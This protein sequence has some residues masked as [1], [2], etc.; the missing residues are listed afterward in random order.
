MQDVTYDSFQAVA[1]VRVYNVKSQVNLTDYQLFLNNTLSGRY[2]VFYNNDSVIYTIY[3]NASSY[4]L[5]FNKTSYQ[6]ETYFFNATPYDNL[7][8]LLNAGFYVSFLFIDEYT[9]GPFNISSPD[10]LKFVL[11][12]ED[13]TRETLIVSDGQ[14]VFVDCDYTKLRFIPQYG[15]VSYARTFILPWEEVTA[16]GN[17]T[18]YLVNLDT[19]D[20]VEVSFKLD[21]LLRDY[22]NPRVYI[23]KIIND[24]SEQMHADYTDI[25]NKVVA[26]L[27]QYHE[28]TI[29]V[30][31]DNNPVYTL[32]TY[33]ADQSGDKILSL[34]EI[35]ITPTAGTAFYNDVSLTAYQYN[36]TDTTYVAFRYNDSANLTSQVR[37]TYYE[38]DESGS[39]ILDAIY[40]NT[41]GI[42]VT[43]NVTSQFDAGIPVLVKSTMIAT[44]GS[45]HTYG[46]LFFAENS[47]HLA[48]V[49]DFKATFDTPE[50]AR[51]LLNWVVIVLLTGLSL[52]AS[53]KTANWMP[54]FVAG[55]A[56]LLSIFGIFTL[57]GW[58]IGII[59]VFALFTIL[60]AGDRKR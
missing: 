21:D 15:A 9:L 7:S 26:T 18:I 32:G 35:A 10:S 57:N 41:P 50:Q 5:D 24:T 19:T 23:T 38:T 34:Y 8:I 4:A 11:T 56:L 6:T 12:C 37:V 30:Y 14:E 22:D 20:Y 17:T 60:A 46:R 58:I 28:Y 29:S 52:L 48:I 36:V 13:Y 39:V 27:I 47:S 45:T 16:G 42:L 44:H 54:F 51:N 43:Q 33:N 55:I 49:D 1:N 31:S 3:L 25:E 59:L 40:N 2:D 53:I